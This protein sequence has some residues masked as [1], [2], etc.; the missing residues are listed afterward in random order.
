MRNESVSV[1]LEDMD[2]GNTAHP[3]LRW[4]AVMFPKVFGCLLLK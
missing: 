3:G 1:V 4:E 2:E